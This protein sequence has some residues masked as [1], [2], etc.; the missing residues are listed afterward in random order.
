MYSYDSQSKKMDLRQLIA[1]YEIAKRTYDFV[2][3]YMGNHTINM[4]LVMLFLIGN[5]L[6]YVKFCLHVIAYLYVNNYLIRL[7]LYKFE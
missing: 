4:T 1:C 2:M 5:N 3:T 7:L 6:Y